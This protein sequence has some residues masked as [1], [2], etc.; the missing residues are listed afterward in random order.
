MFFG[1]H[2]RFQLINN[3]VGEYV[4]VVVVVVVVVVVGAFMSIMSVY[5]CI[6]V[7]PIR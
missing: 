6:Y 5:I 1:V 2:L 7:C 4:F 3:S